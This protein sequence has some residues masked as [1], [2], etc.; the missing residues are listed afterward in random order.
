MV[1]LNSRELDREDHDVAPVKRLA[2]RNSTAFAERLRQL[3]ITHVL[4]DCR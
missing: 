1:T 3:V 4:S 2:V